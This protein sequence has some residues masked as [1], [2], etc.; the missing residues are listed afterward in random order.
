M[1]VSPTW[2]EK[3]LK[4][5]NI[6]DWWEW[7]ETGSSQ[8]PH[9]AGGTVNAFCIMGGNL[10]FVFKILNV[11]NPTVLI[12]ELSLG[13][14]FHFCTRKWIQSRTYCCSRKQENTQ[15]VTGSCPKEGAPKSQSWD[16]QNMENSNGCNWL[17]QSKY[18]KIHESILI[19]EK[20]ANKTKQTYLPSLK[21]TIIPSLYSKIW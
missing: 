6:K 14:H 12:S 11:H 2:L 3:L 7:R 5:N 16:K 20:G 1:P 4:F 21:R 19:Y 13:N 9:G 10:M 8:D 17:K 15:W 18:I